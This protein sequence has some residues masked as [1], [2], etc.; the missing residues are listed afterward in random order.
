MGFGS[1][2]DGGYVGLVVLLVGEELV[3]WLMLER[4]VSEVDGNLMKLVVELSY[5]NFG[6]VGGCLGEVMLEEWR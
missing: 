4:G 5:G 2:G 1:G 3:V 6:G